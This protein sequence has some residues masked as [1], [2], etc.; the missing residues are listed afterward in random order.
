[1]VGRTGAE[2]RAHHGLCDLRQIVL[3]GAERT[4]SCLALLGTTAV[5]D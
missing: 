5:P 2:T 3:E 1:M 4:N